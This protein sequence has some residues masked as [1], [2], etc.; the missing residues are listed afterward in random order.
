M[1]DATAHQRMKWLEQFRNFT[2][3]HPRLVAARDELLDAIEGATPGSLV[4][5][6]GPT[7]VGK[8]TLRTKVEQFLEQQMPPD[9]GRL[10]FVSVDVPPPQT[11]RFRWRDY[12]ARLLA[13]MNEPLIHAKTIRVNSDA[14]TPVA[15]ILGDSDL[16]YAAEQALRHR[17][18]RVV[19][20]DEAQH[21]GRVASGRRLSDQLDV[22]KAM[23][24]RTGT[25]HV[26]LGTYEL[27]AFRNLSAQLSRRCLDLHLQRYRADSAADRQIFQ[28]VLLTFQK[29]LPFESKDTDLPAMWDFLYERSIGCIGILKEWLVRASVR[30]IRHSAAFTREHLDATALSIS[31]CEKILAETREGEMRLNDSE[32]AK[33]RFRA[34]LGIERRDDSAAPHP[35]P[36][37][38]RAAKV[39]QRSPRRDPIREEGVAEYA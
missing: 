13:A 26:L 33:F 38:R 24:N 29:Q 11:G 7:G 12:F 6:L 23:A 5:V 32:D 22:M 16:S 34:L 36:Q 20:V 37:N 25:V 18:P 35:A 31:Q 15:A 8:T 4:I 27:L 9:S 28:S 2:M 19:F 17:R 3:A 21:L 10:P 1:P 14:P 30:A 39:G